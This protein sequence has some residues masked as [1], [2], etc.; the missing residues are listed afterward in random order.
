L[1]G[2]AW[3]S[4]LAKDLFLATDLSRLQDLLAGRYV[5][6]REI[7]RG[8]MATVYLA[9]DPRP[10]RRVALKVLN[11][12]VGEGHGAQRFHR[13]IQFAAGLT[14]P[15][16]LPVHDSGEVDGLLF[17]VM[18]Y[19]EGES[20][21]QR[22]AREGA[23]PV[24]EVLRVGREVAQA[25]AYAHDQGIVHRDIKP[26]NILFSS[27]HAVV[28]DFGV[29]RAMD[30]VGTGQLTE[31]NA[32]VGSPM[33]MSPEQAGGEPDLDG[34]SDVYSLGCVLYEALAGR[35]PFSGQ[36]AIAVQ[37]KRLLEAPPPLHH[38]RPDLAPDVERLVGHAMAQDRA[39][40]LPSAALAAA[41][42]EL[43]GGGTAQGPA[44][45]AFPPAQVSIAVLPF[46]NL[47]P[48]PGNE[49]FSDGM[50]EEVMGM[51]ARVPGLR[52]AARSSSFAFKGKDR[53]IA[54]VGL[55][56]KVGMVLEGSVRKEGNRLRISTQL[57]DTGGGYQLWSG[58]YDRDLKDVFALQDE[59]A[60]AI[61]EELKLK[62][63]VRPG[64]SSSDPR[65]TNVE[66]Y[67]SYL[68]G[69]YAIQSRSP[70]GL[71]AGIAYCEAALALDPGY[72]LAY[73]AIAEAWAMLG[74]IEFSDAPPAEVVPKARAA[75]RKALELDPTVA[76]AHLSLGIV[77]IVHDLDWAAGEREILQCLELNPGLSGGHAWRAIGLA[78][79]G[80]FPEALAQ[81]RQAVE[82]DP[83][84]TSIHQ[85]LGR[86]LYWARQY[87]G[88]VVQL[89]STLEMD[90]RNVVTCGWLARCYVA[91]GRLDDAVEILT[92][93]IAAGGRSP[94]LIGLLGRVLGE[95]GR[96]EEATELLAELRRRGAAFQDMV[97][98]GLGDVDAALAVLEDNLRGHGGYTFMM[99]VDPFMDP[100]RPHPRFQALLRK[101][102]LDHVKPAPAL[103]P[104]AGT[105]EGGAE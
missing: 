104:L 60:H 59:L 92:R 45:P 89:L 58:T 101:L 1:T 25:L 76:E 52:V 27:G 79:Q 49:Y 17:Y 30:V 7:G 6:E 36:T 83:L 39:E 105:A 43:E 51:L 14:H 99:G 70:E 72:A 23:L 24:R 15:H 20:F 54:E 5:L 55:R 35:P 46:L 100:W 12:S 34:R 44:P 47:S 98:T 102:G 42:A 78:S 29:A 11:P 9:R 62:L 28:A 56:L 48:E 68:K 77:A 61:A 38:L 66:A 96:R 86:C 73:A 94:L 85:V 8:G 10:A 91:L 19:V 4:A 64:S 57:V 13:E 69:R 21:R 50:T 90:P 26:E 40:R 31:V 95:Q 18:P 93:G 75:A 2:K 87:P 32:T 97:L 84:S 67:A 16:I 88:A 74:F 22:L 33:Y 65:R 71:R 41:I 37:V 53:D 3:V 81:A 82:L 63:L 103:T 80:R